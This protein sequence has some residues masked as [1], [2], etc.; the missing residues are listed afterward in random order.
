MLIGGNLIGIGTGGQ[1]LGAGSVGIRTVALQDSVID[2]NQIG[3]FATNGLT[4]EGS[5]G[6]TVQSNRI[7]TDGSSGDH[8][9]G[10]DG[11]RI[12][13][14]SADPATGNTIGGTLLTQQNVISNNAGDA[15]GIVGDGN[16]GNQIRRNTG[17]PNGTDPGDLF[18]D[19]VGAVGDGNGATGPNGGIDPP[20]L[21]AAS[22][23]RSVG[24]GPPGATVAA[25]A[26]TDGEF[27]SLGG[28]AGTAVPDS[29]GLWVITHTTP[30]PGGQG[31]AHT[32][33][34]ADGTSEL[35]IVGSGFL[36]PPDA[37]APGAAISAGPSGPTADTTPSF[38]LDDPSADPNFQIFLCATDAGLYQACGIDGSVYTTTALSEGPHSVT[39]LGVD[40]AANLSAPLTRSFT[41]DSVA[42]STTITKAPKSKI[43]SKSKKVKVTFSFASSE[44]GQGGFQ[45]QLDNAA[46]EPCDAGSFTRKVK[47]GKH[48]FRVRAFDAA[49]NA[50]PTLEVRSFKILKKKTKK[51]R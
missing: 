28:F 47:R 22:A 25:F 35:S 44:P 41:V 17:G 19:L 12:A 29:R 34:T 14:F 33:S 30:P 7:G 36:D 3:G 45:C 43:S 13:S 51:K 10:V 5:D 16:D 31:L 18:I 39:V 24:L 26:H 20:D 23:A 42:P 6:T 40:E 32:Q 15:I 4:L 1:A 48:T 27:S 2:G 9:N 8:G 38:T 46:F 49:A 37:A 11:I 21:Q 50:D